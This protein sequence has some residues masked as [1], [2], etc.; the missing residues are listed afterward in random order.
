MSNALARNKVDSNASLRERAIRLLT[1]R[2]H[3]RA[4][5]RR[6]LAPYDEAGELDALLDE[7]EQGRQL[8]DARFAEALA[9]SRSD[10]F[11]SRRLGQELRDRGVSEEL[12]AEAVARAR[13]ADLSAARLVWA[14]KFS[15]LPGDAKTRAQQYRFLLA[16]G[17]PMDVVRRVVGGEDD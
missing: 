11:G 16:R 8:S 3:S 13:D 14:K 7:L 4:E 17:F 12:V 6:K 1:R 9:H 2:E 10:R 5:L 15:G